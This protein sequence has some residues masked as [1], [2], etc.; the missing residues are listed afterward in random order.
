[1]KVVLLAGGKGTRIA[2]ESETK[3][4]PL[5]EIGGMP[6]LWHI[7]KAYA[8]YGFN[9]FIICAGYKQEMIK[10]WFSNYFLYTSDVTFD[11]TEYNNIIIHHQRAESW[12]VTIV[13]TGKDTMTGG[14][15][16]RV[17]EYIDEDIFMMTYGDGVCD[18]NLKQLLEF[19][20]GHGKIATLTS[21]SVRPDKG[22]LDIDYDNTVRA[23]REKQN[24]DARLINAGYMVFNTKIFEYLKDDKTILEKEPMENLI[25]CGE[26]MSYFHDGFWQCMD[27]LREKQ[28]LEKLWESNKA[29]WKIW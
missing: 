2:E 17:R 29:P 16:R 21:V 25:Q 8:Y 6:I 13:D 22:A 7:M 15:I 24:N 27:T 4:K 1:M 19:H 5:I 12:K 20:Q 18:V 23:F 10:N 28:Q 11:F 14:R 3:P 9:E 26:L